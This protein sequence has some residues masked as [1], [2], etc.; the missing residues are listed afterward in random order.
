MKRVLVVLLACACAS[1][2]GAQTTTVVMTPGTQVPGAPPPRD[3]SGPRKTGTAI[4]RGTVV[5]AD[6]GQPL[7]KAQVR[8]MSP[9]LRENRLATTDAGGKYEIKELPAG[10]YTL[11]VS[12]GSFVT[13]SYGQT[14]P[15]ESGKPLEIQD[16]QTIEKVDFVLPR[17]SVVTGRIVDEFGEPATDVMVML[18]RYQVIGGRR[19]LV[20]AGRSNQTNDIGEFRLYAIP[21]GQYY[22]TAT[23]RNTGTPFDSSDDRSGYAPTYFPGTPTIGEAQ[24][25]NIAVGQTLTDL[26]MTLI[27]T[28]LARVSG[29]ALD[30]RGRPMGGMVMAVPKSADVFGP[31][32]FTPSQIRPDGTFSISGVS[33]GTYTLQVPGNGGADNESASLEIT[34]S[35]E[36][37]TDARLVGVKPSTLTGRVVVDPALAQSLNLSALRVGFMPTQPETI[38][39]NGGPPGGVNDDLTFESKVRPGQWRVNLNQL[40]AGWAL[41]A[42]RHRGSDLTDS[43]FDVRPGEDIADVEIELTN[44]MPELSGQVTNSRGATVKDYTVVAFP[45]DREKWTLSNSRYIRSARPDQD[46][47]FKITS[48]P[49]GRYYIVALDQVEQGEWTD[50]EFLDRVQSKTTTVAVGE[51]ETKTVDLKLNSTS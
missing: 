32:M 44:R 33:A 9:E 13:L 36:D 49:P 1:A 29:T 6:S 25:V 22:L 37:I 47:R 4:L 7:R 51:G 23:M 16:A 50:P 3:A 18:Q 45:E 27:P 12:K 28:K 11:S 17:G 2:A 34:V 15:F 31:M 35:G 5:A 48:L 19:R 38:V 24:R 26:N 39:F 43:G 8:I 20:S 14:R 42:V 40:P 21:P 10:R 41:K 46:G 30:S